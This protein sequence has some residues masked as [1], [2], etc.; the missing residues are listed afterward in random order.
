MRCGTMSERAPEYAVLLCFDVKVDRE[1]EE[2]A[3]EMGVKIFSA[4]IIYHLFDSFTAYQKV[5]PKR[6][7]YLMNRT[8]SNK[9]ER[10]LLEVQYSPVFS[11]LSRFS[12]RAIRLFLVLMSS[13]GLSVMA[14]LS[15]QSKSMKSP[16]NVQ[17]IL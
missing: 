17:F 11:E 14:L 13:R 1:A 8:Y 7:I 12:V 3:A 15:L 6:D 4:N 2:T 5:F 16:R 9:R 10:R